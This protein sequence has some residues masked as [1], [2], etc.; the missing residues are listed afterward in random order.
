MQDHVRDHVFDF[1]AVH[2]VLIDGVPCSAEGRTYG[3]PLQSYR[4]QQFYVCPRSGLLKRVKRVKQPQQQTQRRM[5]VVR[6]D[7]SHR[8]MFLEGRWYLVTLHP[9]PN[10]GIADM[11]TLEKKDVALNRWITRK[12]ALGLYGVAAHAVDRRLLGKREMRQLPIPI[13]LQR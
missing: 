3:L 10:N 4:R 6:V 8:C 1:V 2:T 5:P 9:F 7:D 11:W 13:D 12:E